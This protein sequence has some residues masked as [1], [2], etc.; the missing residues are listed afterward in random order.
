MKPHVTASFLLAAM[1]AS[2]AE[3]LPAENALKPSRPKQ[4]AK[5]AVEQRLHASGKRRKRAE[6]A[7]RLAARNANNQEVP[8][9]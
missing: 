7:A 4:D 5:D 6:K 1:L 3:F 9:G 2:S 8:R